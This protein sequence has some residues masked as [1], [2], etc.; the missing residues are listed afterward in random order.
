[1]FN[2]RVVERPMMYVGPPILQLLRTVM[3]YFPTFILKRINTVSMVT[4]HIYFNIFHSTVR[5]YYEYING[6]N[7]ESPPKLDSVAMVWAIAK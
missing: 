4:V 2:T 1:M 7:D 6:E 5:S 3:R